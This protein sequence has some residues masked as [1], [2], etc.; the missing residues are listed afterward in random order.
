MRYQPGFG[1][2]IK[3]GFVQYIAIFFV[4]K[5]ALS[6]LEVRHASPRRSARNQEPA[7]SAVSSALNTCYAGGRGKPYSC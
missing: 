2:M 7:R 6:M 5:Y 3:Y 4:V 1:E